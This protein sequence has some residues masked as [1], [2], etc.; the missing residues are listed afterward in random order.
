MLAIL[1]D[2][3]DAFVDADDR[4]YGVG[5]DRE[6]RAFRGRDEMFGRDLETLPDDHVRDIEQH[7]A[8]AKL[9]LAIRGLEPFEVEPSACET[10][11]MIARWKRESQKLRL[12]RFR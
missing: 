3:D 6:H 12:P 5:L 1:G 7:R 9:Q 11:E 2:L 4:S 8:M 10:D